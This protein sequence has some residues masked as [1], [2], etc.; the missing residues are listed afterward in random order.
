MGVYK[1][2]RNSLRQCLAPHVESCSPRAS[3]ELVGYAVGRCIIDRSLSKQTG[4]PMSK[5]RLKEKTRLLFNR[6]R[7]LHLHS[8]Q[9]PRHELFALVKSRFQL[10]F[11]RRTRS[12]LLL[13]QKIRNSILNARKVFGPYRKL[14]DQLTIAVQARGGQFGNFLLVTE[15][16]VGTPLHRRKAHVA[17]LHH[18]LV[19]VIQQ[20]RMLRLDLVQVQFEAGT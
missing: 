13:L 14:L 1:Y 6:N 15:L 18:I 2:Y 3:S 12:P 10:L 4:S 5:P 11:F 9:Y 17:L 7:L 20:V 19:I 8:I 16:R